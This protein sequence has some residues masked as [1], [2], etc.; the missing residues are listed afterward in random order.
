M[1][2]LDS[3][4]VCWSG[5]SR[6]D[7]CILG[8]RK[9]KLLIYNS[10]ESFFLRSHI[11]ALMFKYNCA[12]SKLH[13]WQVY[14]IHSRYCKI[15]IFLLY[16]ITMNTNSGQ[17]RKLAGYFF[18]KEKNHAKGTIITETKPYRLLIRFAYQKDRYRL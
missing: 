13:Q 7:T 8:F 9:D 3:P 1:K 5:I 14:L 16:I 11:C 12:Y 4:H 18:R 2:I 17:P 6:M 15:S 10:N